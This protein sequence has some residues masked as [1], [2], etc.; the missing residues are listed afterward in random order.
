LGCE[1]AS[2]HPL[3][4]IAAESRATFV[5]G[6]VASVSPAGHRV[7]CAGGPDLG[8]DNLLLASG[9]RMQPP[10]ADAI[11]FGIAGSGQAVKRMLSRLR[12]EGQGRRAL[13]GHARGPSA[14]AV[15][16]SG[17]RQSRP[18]AGG[19]GI[20]FIGATEATVRGGQATLGATGEAVAADCVVTLP[21]LSGP[22]LA[23]VPA[24]QPH[25]FVPVD[26]YGRVERLADVYTAGD[27]V[28]FPTKQGGLAAQQAGTVAA[29]HGA[30][31]DPVPF[32]PL[33]RGMLFTG[34]EPQFMRSDLPGNRSRNS[35]HLVPAVVAAD[36]DRRSLLGSVPDRARRVG[37]AQRSPRGVRRRARAP[38]R[39]GAGPNP[40]PGDRQRPAVGLV[41][42]TSR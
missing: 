24:T 39:L 18:I 35:R 23:D 32:L 2:R 12:S 31:V 15:R 38:R 27:S 25:G 21:L 19:G 11:A 36:E 40:G 9:A 14:C 33:L 13:G 4:R 7:S 28:D 41:V 22:G 1:A 16:R 17:K 5:R 30:P 8:Y 37:G 6:T 34:A 42:S 26:E 29:R 3:A 20:E 10:F